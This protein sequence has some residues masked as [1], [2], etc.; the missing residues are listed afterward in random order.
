MYPWGDNRRFNSYTSYIKRKFGGRV[1][2]LT[3]DAGFTC[4][5]RD[6]SIGIDGCSYCNNDAFN[7]SYCT[8]QKSITQ[9]LNEGIDFHKFRYKRVENYFAYFQAYSNTYAPLSKLKELYS[10]A[11]SHPKVSGLVIGTRPDC[12]D[13][14][15]LDYL[16]S[17]SK[18]YYISV[19]YGVESCNNKTLE[20]INRGHSIEKSI[21]AINETA[22][23]GLGVGAHFIIGLPSE[24][25]DDWINQIEIINK[26]PLTSIK[27]HQL[28]IVINTA[29]AEE[30]SRDPCIFNLLSLDEYL[31]L[32]VEIVEHI[33]PNIVIERFTSETTPQILIAP[34]WGSY[35]ADQLLQKFEKMMELKDTWQ[36]KKVGTSF[37]YN[38]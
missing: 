14:E 34:I 29:M 10:E 26:L 9:Q 17:L 13:E 32:M 2:K 38:T 6:G 7:P 12:V 24:S 21:W 1:Q 27:F 11:L 16:A 20:R 4:P 22:K 23:R 3:I 36:G 30:Y 19:E 31:E 35:R 28:Q 5:N 33:N 15:K 37:K 18:D 25:M 8:P